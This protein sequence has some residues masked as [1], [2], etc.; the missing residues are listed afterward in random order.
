MRYSF[1]FASCLLLITAQLTAQQ[2]QTTAYAITSSEKGNFN[3]TDVKQIDFTSGAVT[4]SVFDARQTNFTVFSARTGKEIKPL[5]TNGAT[6]N[7][8]VPVASLSAA[9]AYDQRHNRLYYAPLFMN[10]LRY[11]D[12]DEKEPKIYYFDNEQFSPVTDINNEANHITRM[13]I[14]ADGDGY[15][16]SNDANHLIRFTTGRK[17]VIT[18]LGAL[19][20]DP[21]NGDKS[22]HAKVTGWGGDMIADAAGNLYVI[23]AYRQVFKVNIQS[24]VATWLAEIKGLPAAFTTNGAVVD[25]EGFLIV[26]SANT[27]EG[28]YKVDMSSWAATRIDIQGT[29]FNASDLANGNLAFA[30][31]V[32]SVPLINRALI[33]NEKIALYP[34]PVATNQIYVS[35][36]SK[37]SGRYTILLVTLTGQ[38]ISEKIAVIANGAQVVPVNVK[39]GLSKGTYM[40]K[41]LSN[42]KKAIFTDKL[43]VE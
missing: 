10:Q 33:R 16:L 40:V 9:C 6:T 20:D 38:V 24:K 28:Y 12:L 42:S 41:V 3:W 23:S 32:P 4:R 21:A 25:S 8:T 5:T 39:A 22:I 34:N 14:G 2:R 43:M 15:A 18:D 31:D 7:A 11:I 17:A 27:A 19:Q 30:K 13:V 37:E 35:F 36:N 29:V 1:T 26:S